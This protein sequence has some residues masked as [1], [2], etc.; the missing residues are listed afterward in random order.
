MRE[1]LDPEQTLLRM[2]ELEWLV[3]VLG[4]ERNGDGDIGAQIEWSGSRIKVTSTSP[5]RWLEEN[6]VA[7]RPRL[8]ERGM[9][10][11]DNGWR[12]RP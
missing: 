5:M 2:K 1:R 3:V 7:A 11:L 10:E 9:A 8:F 12:E 4:V 6:A